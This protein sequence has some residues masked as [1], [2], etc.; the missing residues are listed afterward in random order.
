MSPLDLSRSEA[1]LERLISRVAAAPVAPGPG[2]VW[3]PLIGRPSTDRVLPSRGS[4]GARGAGTVCVR[5]VGHRAVIRS[6]LQARPE[7]TAPPGAPDGPALQPART[8]AKMWTRRDAL[9]PQ[10]QHGDVNS[11]TERSRSSSCHSL[12]L[13]A[14]LLHN[15][16]SHICCNFGCHVSRLSFVFRR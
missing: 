5:C 2:A 6:P 8:W 7:Q 3:G 16:I 4:A 9:F 14:A 15:G 1:P 10:K 11:L 13:S 12:F